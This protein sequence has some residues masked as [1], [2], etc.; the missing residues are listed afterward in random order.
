M[1]DSQIVFITSSVNT[2]IFYYN[3]FS[4]DYYIIVSDFAPNIRNLLDFTNDI[5]ITSR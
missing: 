2:I 5:L 3:H 1:G 4:P